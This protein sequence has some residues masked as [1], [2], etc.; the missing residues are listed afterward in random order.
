LRNDKQPKS[1]KGTTVS[2]DVVSWEQRYNFLR[3]CYEVER[4]FQTY[5]GLEKCNILGM[6]WLNKGLFQT[7]CWK[8]PKIN[9][10]PPESKGIKDESYDFQEV[11]HSFL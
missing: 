7:F 6:N 4:T 9:G 3:V 2:S 11:S 5:L 1:K 8:S 10:F